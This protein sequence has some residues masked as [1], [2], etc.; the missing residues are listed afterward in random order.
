MK[1]GYPSN[2]TTLGSV[3]LSSSTVS[4]HL[5]KAT[6]LEKLRS[7]PQKS[8]PTNFNQLPILQQES[9]SKRFHPFHM[10]ILLH[11]MLL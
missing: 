1:L 9:T 7:H 4:P 10:R 3:T 5:G 11:D 8:H 6:L 2:P